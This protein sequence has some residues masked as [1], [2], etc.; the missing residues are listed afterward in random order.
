MI[1]VQQTQAANTTPALIT[2]NSGSQTVLA[3]NPART[4]FSIQN[5]G[6]AVMQICFGPTASTTVYHFA[7]KGGTGN[8]DG[9]GGSITFNTGT[10]YTGLITCYGTS[11]A[12]IAVLE[13]TPPLT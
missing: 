7:L 6:T 8:N 12:I 2:G 9:T 1:S 4:G 5:V 3:A 11:S 13:L 10:I